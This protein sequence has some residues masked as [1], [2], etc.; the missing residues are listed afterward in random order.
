MY[1][2]THRG[3]GFVT[4]KDPASVEAVLSATTPHVLDTKTV[5]S[6]GQTQVFRFLSPS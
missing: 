1:V 4:F 5:V 6:L 3:F 2:C